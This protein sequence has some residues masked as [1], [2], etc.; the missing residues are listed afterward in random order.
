MTAHAHNLEEIITGKPQIVEST[1]TEVMEGETLNP[2]PA[3]GSLESCVYLNWDGSSF[4]CEIYETR[5]LVCR[6]F[7]PGSS[8]LCPRYYCEE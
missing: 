7:I 6:N 4:F 1:M 2:C 8:E 3:T 5:P